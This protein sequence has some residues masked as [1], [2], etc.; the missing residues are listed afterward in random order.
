MEWLWAGTYEWDASHP[1]LARL[2]PAMLASLAGARLVPAVNP[3][4]EAMKV[5]GSGEH[6]D[7]LLAISRAGILPLF[8]IA[9]AMLFL[10]ARRIAGGAAAVASLAVFTTI[11][12]VLAHAGT[13]A[14]PCTISQPK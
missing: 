11:P 6:Y 14:I 2:T 4:D 5:W 1:P 7:R 12:P 9:C 13:G 10:W 8:W 3:I